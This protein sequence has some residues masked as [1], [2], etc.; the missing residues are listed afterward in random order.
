MSTERQIRRITDKALKKAE[1]QFKRADFKPVGKAIVD[2]MRGMIKKG[3][4]PIKTRGRFPGYKNPVKGY[5]TSV[6]KKHPGKRIRPVNLTLTGDQLK[7]LTF[8]V[9]PSRRGQ[10][11]FVGYFDRESKLKEEGHRRGQ[12][13]QP[14]RPTIPARNESFASKVELTIRREVRAIIAKIQKRVTG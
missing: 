2:E 1:K 10:D 5:P 11:L 14:K 7:N 4:S 9:K 12:N 6:K 13:R 3:V 8:K